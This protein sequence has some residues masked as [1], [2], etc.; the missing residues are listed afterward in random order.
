VVLGGWDYE[1]G[2]DSSDDES[3]DWHDGLELRIG[4]DSDDQNETG[5]PTHEFD[6]L[7]F[8]LIRL[9]YIYR[10]SLIVGSHFLSKMSGLRK[11]IPRGETPSQ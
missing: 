8:R 1:E 10:K 11:I 5:G 6:T 2:A 7:K 3:C 4:S 9:T